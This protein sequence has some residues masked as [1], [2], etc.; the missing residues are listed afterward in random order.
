MSNNLRLQ[1]RQDRHTEI[2]LH[3]ITANLT[4]NLHITA[5]ANLTLNLHITATAN[6]ALN[7]HIT[8][9]QT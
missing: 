5:T 4:L 3:H 6:L 7:L 9:Q 2:N 1:V 8:S